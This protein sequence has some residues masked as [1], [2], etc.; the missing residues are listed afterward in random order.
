M[1]KVIRKETALN[2]DYLP[3]WGIYE[4]VKELLQNHVYARQILLADGNINYN[5]NCLIIEDEGPGFGLEMFL[6]GKGEQ[7]N[8]V[9]SP[10]QNAEGMKISFLIAAREN[11]KLVGEIPGF[12]IHAEIENSSFGEQ[13]LVF[14]ATPN[15]R[16]KGTKFTIEVDQEIYKKAVQGFGY[17]S[18]KTEQERES[19]N[20]ASLIDNNKSQIFVNGVLIETPIKTINGYSYNL[21]GKD[22]TNLTNRDRNRISEYHGNS[23]IWKQV[24][25]SITDKNIIANILKNVS[26]NTIETYEGNPYWINKELWKEVVSELYGSKVCYATGTKSDGQARYRKFKVLKTPVNGMQYLFHSLGIVAS[27]SIFDNKEKIKHNMIQLKDLESIEHENI[28]EVRNLIQKHYIPKIWPLRYVDNL[29]DQFDNP[30]SGLCVPD[31]QKIY[32]DKKILKNY[33]ELFR[34]MLHEVVHQVS[35][36]DDNTTEFEWEW[37]NA[38]LSFAKG[39]TRAK[40]K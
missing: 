17:L 9:N 14:Y 13:E 21:I 31:E 34:I 1:Q 11:K 22:D 2:P 4:A 12:N 25:S 39:C 24:I 15:S 20:K 3:N 30:V 5:N 38:C 35:G 26:N 16:T 8:I 19:F 7:K 23:E 32:L 29:K 6:L 28:K 36:A 27:S 18:A 37:A 33:N 10:G 40:R